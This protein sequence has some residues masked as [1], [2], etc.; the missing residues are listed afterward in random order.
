MKVRNGVIFSSNDENTLK[1]LVQD[2]VKDGTK[3]YADDH[4]CY[5]SMQ[6]FDHESIKQSVGESETRTNGLESFWAML[7][8]AHN[9]AFH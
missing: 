5:Q 6:G 7:K 4:I 2:Y 9:G 1:E 3:V 8:R